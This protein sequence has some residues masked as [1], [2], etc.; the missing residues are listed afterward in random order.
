MYIPHDIFKQKIWLK[1]V[2]FILV[3]KEPLRELLLLRRRRQCRLLISDNINS[4]A[5]QEIGLKTPSL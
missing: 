3:K 1:I 2:A 4:D 5:Y